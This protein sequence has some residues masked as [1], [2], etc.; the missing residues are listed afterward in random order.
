MMI[1]PKLKRNQKDLFPERKNQTVE[2]PQFCVRQNWGF[3]HI[4]AKI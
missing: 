4:V 3:E 1:C 2:K